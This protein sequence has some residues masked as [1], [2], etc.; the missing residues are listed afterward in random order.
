M[1]TVIVPVFDIGGVFID[2]NPL[3]LYRKLFDSEEDAVWFLENVCT[4]A[5]N[6]SLDAGKPFFE[7]KAEL[8]AKYPRFWREIEAYD[9]RWDEMVKGLFDEMV[10]VHRGLV[11]AEIPTFAITNFSAEKWFAKLPDWPFMQAFDGVVVSGIEKLV[12]PDPRIFALF[13]DRYGLEPQSCLFFDDN[14]LNVA[15]ARAFG[16]NAIEVK[17]VED[18]RAGLEAFGLPSGK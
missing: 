6:L 14:A 1:D 10:D 5:W 13:C 7:S 12:K 3:Y 9:S 15:S 2:W 11:E 16:M 17:S 8:T 18:V 4:P